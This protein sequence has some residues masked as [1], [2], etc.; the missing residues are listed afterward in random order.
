MNKPREWWI[1]FNLGRPRVLTKE[2]FDDVANPTFKNGCQHVFESTPL[3]RNAGELLKA[4][5]SIVSPFDCLNCEM[6][7]SY[8]GKICREHLDEVINIAKAAIKKAE[9]GDEN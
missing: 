9:G 8:E 2:D 7:G 6:S 4:L 1:W 3:T 5:K